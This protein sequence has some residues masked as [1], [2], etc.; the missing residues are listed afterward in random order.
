[1]LLEP[2]TWEDKNDAYY[3]QEYKRKRRLKTVLACCFSAARETFHHWK[4]FATGP[5]GVCIEFSKDAL[6][7]S[8]ERVEGARAD[9]VKYRLISENGHPA[10]ETWPFLKR[11]AFKDEKEF[12]ILYESRKLCEK[13]K[14]IPFSLDCIQRITLSPWLSKCVAETVNEIIRGIDGCDRLRVDASNLIDHPRW[15]QCINSPRS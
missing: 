6:L 15:R 14:E 3:L 9:Y 1:M 10:V 8:L 7:M 4:V 5:S 13:T 12:R 2:T 11:I